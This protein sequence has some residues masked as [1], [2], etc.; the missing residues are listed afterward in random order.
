MHMWYA[1]DCAACALT[2]RHTAEAEAVTNLLSEPAASGKQRQ[3]IVIGSHACWHTQ[4][5]CNVV[6]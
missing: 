1:L 2:R 3:L 5:D 4:S 6:A